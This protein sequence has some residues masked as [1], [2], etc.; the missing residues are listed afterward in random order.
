MISIIQRIFV[1]VVFFCFATSVVAQVNLPISNTGSAEITLPD[2]LTP[3][4]VRDLVSTLS[5]EQVRAMLLERLDAVA[6]NE[7]ESNPKDDVS[8][9][10]FVNSTSQGV[11]L[12]VRTAIIRLPL[13]WSSQKESFG[14]FQQ[15][16]GAKDMITLFGSLFLALAAGLVAEFAAG[17]ITRH[18]HANAL[19]IKHPDTLGETIRFLMYRLLHE[20]YGVVAFFII[21]RMVIGWTLPLDPL[22]VFQVIVFNMIVVPRIGAAFARFFLAPKKPEIRLLYTDDASAKILYRH[23]IGML[24]LIGF[25]ITIVEFNDLNGVPVG[26]TYL[27]FWLNISIH[28]Y[29]IWII[30]RT[31]DGLVMIQRGRQDV[32]T[33]EDRVARA[34]PFFGIVV[35]VSMWI[36]FVI[37][38][39]YELYDLLLGSPHFKTMALLLSAPIFDTLVRGLVRYLVPPMTGVGASAERAYLSTKRSYIHIGRILLFAIVMA[40]ISRIW[41][42]NLGYLKAVGVGSQLA[43]GVLE[44]M[45]ILALGYLLTELVSLWVN[46]KMAAEQT[47]LGLD[48]D[49]QEI[50]GGEGGGAGGSRLST[51]LPLVLNISKTTIAIVVMLIA[52]GNIGIDIRPLLAGAG[53]IGLAIGFGAQKLVSDIVSGIFFLLDDA[54]RVGEYVEVEGT[55]GTVEK[56]SIRSMQLR[57]HKGPVHTIPYGEIPKITN[58]S[59]D[60]VIVKLKFTVAIKAD[61]QK[62]KKIFKKIGAEMMQVPEYKDDF[63]QPFKSQGVFD[64]DDLG[65]IIRGK[66]MAKPG[67]QWMIRKEIFNRVKTEFEAEGIKFARRE[68]QVTV[69]GV[70]NLDHLSEEDK[71]VIT[72]AANETIQQIEQDAKTNKKK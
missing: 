38:A 20:L 16:L 54:F 39:S 2:P 22:P 10:D 17:K 19:A 66:F 53:I 26:T 47:A 8:L 6:K 48:L 62:I 69:P 57:H 46:R 4:T 40:L 56:I 49:D 11:F 30:W 35:S 21:A 9:L 52:L 12:T 60:W 32:T 37:V 51:V 42:V 25:T 45:L 36:L 34:Y 18:W 1:A 3:E 65:M 13:L 7:V 50:G 68:V 61:P 5:D 67:K 28:I 71:A 63:L 29:A 55:V 27:G 14:N 31:W 23:L 72:A 70:D 43:S 41:G 44:V 58:Y 24:L 33:I 15:R 64:F 59:R